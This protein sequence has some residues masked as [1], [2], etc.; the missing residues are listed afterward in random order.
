MF[1]CPPLL[2][3]LVYLTQGYYNFG[4]ITLGSLLGLPSDGLYIKIV[5]ACQP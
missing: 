4:I 3:A 1:V 2:E 5:V